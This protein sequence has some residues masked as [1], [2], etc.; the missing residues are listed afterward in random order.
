MLVL[1]V[2][3]LLCSFQKKRE[4]SGGLLKV[5]NLGKHDRK[6]VLVFC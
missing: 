1:V 5:Q 3:P 6:A 2:S 4:R